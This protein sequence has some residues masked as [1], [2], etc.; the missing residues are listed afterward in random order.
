MSS[1]PRPS[2]IRLG[3]RTGGRQAPRRESLLA[4]RYGWTE[5]ATTLLAVAYAGLAVYLVGTLGLT[6]SEAIARTARAATLW[7]GYHVTMLGFGFDRPPLLNLLTIPFAAFEGLREHGLATTL[8]TALASALALPVALKVARDAG[9]TRTAAL[10]FVLAFVANPVLVYAGVFGL[11]ETIYATL[12]LVALVEFGRWVR[13]RTVA[14]VITSGFAL[15][16]AFLLRYNVL[17]LVAVMAWGYWYI[18]RT[19]ERDTHEVDSAQANTLA[20][21]V[22]VVFV[23][24]LWS[25]IAWFPRGEAMEYLD[26]ARQVTALGNDDPLVISRVNDLRGDPLAVG[27]W[28]GRWTLLIAP[29]SILATAGLAAYAA[30]ARQRTEGVL[31]V[32]C[33]AVLLPEAVA[34]LGGWGQ[35]HVP[36]LFVAVVPA[37]A[38]LAYRERAITRGIPPGRYEGPRRRAQIVTTGVLLVASLASAAAIWLMPITDQPAVDL[39]STI[40]LG[41]APSP[42]TTDEVEMARYIR[43]HAGPGDVIADLNRHAEVM[44]LAGDPSLFRTSASEGDE[45]TLYEPFET[46]RWLLVRRPIAGQGP[47]RIEQAYEDLFEDGSGSLALEFQSGEYRLYSVTGPALP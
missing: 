47:G 17:L 13:D 42:Y 33:A 29:A 27:Q 11:P 22:P 6:S 4:L 39:E 8:G 15:G 21:L 37:F 44:L 9:L 23:V 34:L 1:T 41:A 12:V 5:F 32:V 16:A 24:G 18:A 26:L 25:L 40:R 2:S 45:A 35:A 36:H 20:F 14:S 31:A 46:A 38:I 28:I 30:W 3:A 7:D 19:E 10:L 43:A